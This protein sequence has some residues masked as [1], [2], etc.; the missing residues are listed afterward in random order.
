MQ[1]MKIKPQERWMSWG[2]FVKQ[3]RMWN[4]EHPEDPVD[5]TGVE[6]EV[7]PQTLQQDDAAIDNLYKILGIE[8]CK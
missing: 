3:A 2:D 6:D 5:L 4:K 7:E 8:E 1:A